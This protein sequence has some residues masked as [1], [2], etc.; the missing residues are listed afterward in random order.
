M[1]RQGVW[2]I[3]ILNKEARE[4]LTEKVTFEHI[5]EGGEGVSPQIPG[6]DHY[7]QRKQLVQKWVRACLV[8]SEDSKEARWLDLYKWGA[9]R[10]MREEAGE[11]CRWGNHLSHF[12]PVVLNWGQFVSQGTF[13]NVWRHFW[14]TPLGAF[15]FFPSE[16]LNNSKWA[17]YMH[18]KLPSGQIVASTSD[19]SIRF[20][21]SLCKLK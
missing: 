21:N 20:Q 7:R 3:Q 16:T 11:R 13:G 15:F 5:L 2:R 18:R 4:S 17:L 19:T 14:L 1:E 6:R 10:K 8:Y 12:K 9:E